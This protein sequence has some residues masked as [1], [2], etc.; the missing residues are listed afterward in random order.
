MNI[1]YRAG[2]WSAAH[3]KTATLLWLVAVICAVIGGRIAGTVSLTYSQQLSERIETLTSSRA[4][5][6]NVQESELRA[7]D[8]GIHPPVLTD[9]GLEAAGPNGLTFASICSRTV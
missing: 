3:W 1:A 4:G 6:L 7:L 5:A 9:R 2:R 8:R